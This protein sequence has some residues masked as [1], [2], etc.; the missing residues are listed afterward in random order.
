VVLTPHLDRR[1][2]MACAAG[3]TLCTL[4]DLEALRAEALLDERDLGVVN[5][6]A[7]VELRT[8]A[9]PGRL[10]H[11]AI[12]RLAPLPSGGEVRRFYRVLIRVENEGQRL[13]PG[14]TG[15]VRFDAGRASLFRQLLEKL[16]AI[17]RIEFWV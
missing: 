5:L 2:G 7:P 4:G 13:R 3:D 8:H 16:A 14:L 17:F 12:E 6:A 11:G 15:T 1:V 9:A 10:L